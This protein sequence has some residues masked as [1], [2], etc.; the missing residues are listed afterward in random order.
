MRRSAWIVAIAGAALLFGGCSIIKAQQSP[1]A[2]TGTLQGVITGPSGPIANA[3]VSVTASDATQHLGQSDT[4]GFYDIAAVP[5]GPATFA[6]R[7]PGFSEYDGSVVITADPNTNRQDV[8][9]NP[10]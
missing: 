8:S 7:A 6:V 2:T 3:S 9:L 10:Q 1:A 5:T 4:G